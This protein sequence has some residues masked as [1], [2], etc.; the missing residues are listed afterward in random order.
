LSPIGAK[1]V[2]LRP[3]EGKWAA[4]VRFLVSRDPV[5]D[6]KKKGV[7]SLIVPSITDH[8]VIPIDF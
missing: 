6:G 3:P 8:G 5:S 1:T 7:I 2:T 4:A